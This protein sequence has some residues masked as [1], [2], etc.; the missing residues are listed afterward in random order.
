LN[1]AGRGNDALKILLI[2]NLYPSLEHPAFG[3]F[4]S[5]RVDALKRAGQNV[6]VVAITDPSVRRAI[7]RKYATLAF[8]AFGA[9]IRARLSH[10]PFDIVEAHIA[11]PTGLIGLAASAMGGGR[12]VLFAHGSDVREVAWRSRPITALARFVFRH[13]ALVIANSSFTSAQAVRLGP[14]KRA[15]IVVSPGVVLPTRERTSRPRARAGI[16]FVGRL[17]PEKGVRELLVAVAGLPRPRENPLTVVGEGAQRSELEGLAAALPIEATFL[18]PLPPSKVAELMDRAAIVAMPSTYEEPLGL[19]AIE[20]M[21]HGALVVATRTGG[22]AETIVD[23]VNAFAVAPGDV[24]GLTDALQRAI[25]LDNSA[26]EAM[27]RA[28]LATAVVHDVDSSVQASL[29]AY[30]SLRTN[31]RNRGS[32]AEARSSSHLQWRRVR[33]GAVPV[34]DLSLD[35]T[36]AVV[37]DFVAARGPHRYVAINVSKV[38]Q[39]SR[40]P[41]LRRII[42]DTDVLTADGLPIVWASR[43]LGRP[44]RERV[45]GIDL[46]NA[47]IARAAERGYSIFFLGAHQAIVEA[48]VNRARSEFPSLAVA[49]WQNGYWQ[50]DEE[51]AVVREIAAA[52]PDILFVA[53]GSPR[54]EEFLDRWQTLMDVPFAMG[55]G[56]SF[57]VYAGV[58]RRAPRVLQ[59]LGLEWLFRVSQEPRR[60]LGRYVADAPRFAGIVVRDWIRSKR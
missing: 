58:V 37:D 48:V 6:T 44:L 21:A 7:A 19:V 17:T 42:G 5:T 46:M 39:A 15:P 59:R 8:R 36:L 30:A 11:F 4:M 16:L 12:L 20:G 54:K 10:K 40:D 32:S 45:S 2:S 1:H 27:R 57:D 41:D 38:V 25:T 53:M 33:V 18:G 50:S 28:A 23:G 49:G 52:K 55:V 43:L 34:D 51:E 60:L 24:S 13:A 56:G 22:L 29:S 26:A 35:E 47:L 9:A 3:T 31:G 14:L